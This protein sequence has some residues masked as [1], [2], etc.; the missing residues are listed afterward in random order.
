[1]LGIRSGGTASIHRGA[2]VPI[3]HVSLMR[4]GASVKG[5]RFERIGWRMVVQVIRAPVK[6]SLVQRGM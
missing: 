6:S 3:P 2:Y 4:P 1:M 5:C